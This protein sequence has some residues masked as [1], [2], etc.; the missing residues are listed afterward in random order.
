MAN[1]FT[2]PLIRSVTEDLV[3]VEI[4]KTI[5]KIGLNEVPELGN[6]IFA[7]KYIDLPEENLVS[8]QATREYLEMLWTQYQKASKTLRGAILDELERNLG[9]HRKSA[10]RLM[11]RK[12]PPRSLQGFK[13]GRRKKY[14]EM[15]KKHL[16]RLWRSM[17]FM[18]PGR[19]KAVLSDWLK[20]DENSECSE[21]IRKELLSMSASTIGRFLAKARADL[22]RKLNTGTRKGVRRFITKVPIRNFL[23][24]PKVPGHCEVDCV[25][26]CGGSLSGSFAW[27]VNLTDIATGWTECEAVWGKDGYS[28]MKAIERMERRLPFKLIAIYVDN[29]SEFLNEDVVERYA[30]NR[31]PDPIQVF[32]GRPYRKND[33]AYIEQK[34]YTHVRSIMGYG[35]IDWEKTVGQMN[36][37]YRKE[38]RNLQ[39]FFMPQQKLVEKHREGA[40]VKRKMDSGKTPFERLKEFLTDEQL[41]KLS[42]EK[43]KLNPFKL[44]NNQRSKVRQMFGYYKNSI[45]KDEWGKMAS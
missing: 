9:L 6:H 32:R 45:S 17:G 43:E 15:A 5:Q 22:T 31:K 44:R 36:D 40:K 11:G 12:Y 34:N 24:T 27:T 37:L 14:S 10:T 2:S 1:F 4:L 33:Q 21:E 30:A 20:H 23:E 41:R 13:G 19:M 29:G 26:H 42:E 7:K 39:N 38:W 8:T 28:V 25:A 16:E 18:W 3:S 35:R